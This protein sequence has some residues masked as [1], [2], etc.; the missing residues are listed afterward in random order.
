MIN[1]GYRRKIASGEGCYVCLKGRRFACIDRR[2]RGRRLGSGGRVKWGLG[3]RWG[4]RRGRRRG[5]LLSVVVDRV[6]VVLMERVVVWNRLGRVRR[7]LWRRL[8]LRLRGRRGR[9]SGS[10]RGRRRVVRVRGWLRLGSRS[11]FC[12]A[13]WVL[14]R[15]RRRLWLRCRFSCNR[16]S[17]DSL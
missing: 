12:R 9:R 5:R 16:N 13:I 14:M 2:M 6:V 8:L 3:M 1:P 10:W 4:F 15:C 17:R 7:L 11:R